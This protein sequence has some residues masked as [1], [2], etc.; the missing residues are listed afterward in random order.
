[1]SFDD[2]I[3]GKG[4]HAPKK[5]TKKKNDEGSE[6]VTMIENAVRKVRDED[7]DDDQGPKGDDE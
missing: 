2:M 4:A 5:K 1:M 3:F 7:P 6:L